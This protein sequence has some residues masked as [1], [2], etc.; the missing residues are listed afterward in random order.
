MQVR[1][2]A[3]HRVEIVGPDLDRGLAHLVGRMRHRMRA[4]LEHHDVDA[5]KALAQLQRQR[6]PCEPA[7]HD[8]D[9]VRGG[10]RVHGC[11]FSASS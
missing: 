2:E 6:E 5:G 11:Q 10:A 3:E 9:V 1:L 4:A 8:G 7:A